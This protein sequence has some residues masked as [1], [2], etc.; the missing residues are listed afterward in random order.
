MIVVL[1][2]YSLF[3]FICLRDDSKASVVYHSY[4]RPSSTTNIGG[5]KRS[6]HVC[7][8]H[9]FSERLSTFP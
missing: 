2:R 8:S 4:M 9:A 3:F 6:P 5:T 1:S 7:R